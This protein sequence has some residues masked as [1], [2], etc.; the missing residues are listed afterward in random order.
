MLGMLCADDSLSPTLRGILKQKG[1]G[2]GSCNSF[3]RVYFHFIQGQNKLKRENFQKR[4]LD[5][6]CFS[7]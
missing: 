5:R 4:R 3:L 2:G 6:F 1:E 7:P